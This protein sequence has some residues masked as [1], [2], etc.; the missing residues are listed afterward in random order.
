MMNDIK[1]RDLHLAL[2]QTLSDQF[3]HNLSIEI[4]KFTI[5]K[6]IPHCMNLSKMN[7]LLDRVL[8]VLMLPLCGSARPM[9]F[10]L[11]TAP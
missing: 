4:R 3:N 7:I 2:N 8:N 1:A 5:L 6:M 11:F 9:L 10:L